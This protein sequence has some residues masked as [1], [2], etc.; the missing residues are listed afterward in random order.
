M[1]VTLEKEYKKYGQR[2]EKLFQRFMLFF[3]LL[4]PAFRF[5][6]VM[7]IHFFEFPAAAEQRE[8]KAAAVTKRGH[9][10][11]ARVERDAEAKGQPEHGK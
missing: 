6:Q 1:K 8:D 10:K 11:G 4:V 2:Q 9:D 5:Q 3:D 7:N